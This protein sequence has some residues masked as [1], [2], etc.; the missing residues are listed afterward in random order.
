MESEEALVQKESFDPPRVVLG[1]LIE[2]FFSGQ[3]PVGH[4]EKQ[5]SCHL[6]SESLS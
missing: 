1:P 4:E 3:H 5:R 2:R 6:N